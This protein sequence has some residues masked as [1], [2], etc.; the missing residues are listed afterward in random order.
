MTYRRDVYVFVGKRNF[1]LDGRR[2]E[3]ILRNCV[4]IRKER[5]FR[6]KFFALL[7]HTYRYYVVEK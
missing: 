3:I 2:R 6:E 7:T 1:L 4:I 5:I